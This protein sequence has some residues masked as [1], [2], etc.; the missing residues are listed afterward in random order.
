MP[1]TSGI[2]ILT[3]VSE[4]AISCWHCDHL[5]CRAN[6]HDETAPAATLTC[7]RELLGKLASGLRSSV[8]LILQDRLN[9]TV[10]PGHFGEQ[11]AR[12]PFSREVLLGESS[13]EKRLCARVARGRG[14]QPADVGHNCA[15][16]SGCRHG[17]IADEHRGRREDEDVV[18]QSH[19]HETRCD[20]A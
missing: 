14:E 9:D 10:R 8:E 1:T 17:H 18:A 11:E 5:T 12:A 6:P 13:G 7:Q 15:V 20:A 4:V 2:L 3:R 16:E 19:L